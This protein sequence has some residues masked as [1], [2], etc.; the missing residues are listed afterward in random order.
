[1]IGRML[2]HGWDVVWR[3]IRIF[4]EID[5]EQRAASFAY[6]AV[7][8]L[9]PLFA[10]MLT[11]GSLFVAPDEVIRTFERFFP[12][13]E[14]QQQ[15]IWQMVEA[16]E[17]SRGSVSAVS[18]VI[19]LWCSLRFFQ[20]LVRGVNRAWHTIEIPWWQL[21]LK[22]LLM[23]GVI[24]SALLLGLIAPAILQ[25]A[26]KILT[27]FEE[28]L[29][30]Q[31]PWFNLDVVTSVFDLARYAVAGA[32]LFY[33]FVLLYMLAPRRRVYFRQVWMPSLVVTVALQACQNAFVNYLPRFV[34][35]NAIYGTVG[36]MMLLLLWVYVSGVIII[37]GAC[38]CA[39]GAG[40]DRAGESKTPRNAQDLAG[41]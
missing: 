35:Y 12:V 36:V 16:L 24:A 30:A 11:A 22:N 4:T 31:F 25:G 39:A 15:W 41:S 27:A 2:R 17:R 34:N 3:T 7:F 5:G 6:Y 37:L 21:P 32:V 23:I 26:K 40:E 18:L 8:S 19:L 33:A 9:F 13:G 29:E 20:A 10:L 28:F 1:M 38:L 14:A